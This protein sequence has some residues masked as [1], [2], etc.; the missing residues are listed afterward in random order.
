MF[1]KGSRY[2]NVPEAIYEA[3]SG[4]QVRY[5]RLRILPDPTA[6]QLYRVAAA[7]RLDLIAFRFYR[8]PEQFW[9]IC[10]ANDALLPDDLLAEIGRQLRI[11]LP[12]R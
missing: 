4:R 2:E 10:D 7:D 6:I 5:K 11:P 8:D 9:R 1:A 12:E 3:P